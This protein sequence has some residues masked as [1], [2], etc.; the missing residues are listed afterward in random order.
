[1]RLIDA[2]PIKN[3]IVGGLNNPD[4]KNAFGYDAIQILTE[5]EFAPTVEAVP[6]VHGRWLSE[7]H[8]NSNNGTCSVCGSHEHAYAFGW[9]YCPNCGAR[10]DG[11]G[12][13]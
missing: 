12:H 4:K 13:D 11:E 2:E 9:K 8:G 5:I 6:V 10:M 3:F 7:M 1:M